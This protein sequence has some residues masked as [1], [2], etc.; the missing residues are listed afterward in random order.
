MEARNLMG[1]NWDI[2][3]VKDAPF[4]EEGLSED[5]KQLRWRKL[6]HIIF[7]CMGTGIGY[8]KDETEA[9]EWFNRYQVYSVHSGLDDYVTLD[10]VMAYIGLHTNVSRESR[11][12]WDARMRKL[13]KL[14]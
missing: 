11:F 9:R 2:T 5:E 1:L 10:D 7:A 8:I 4:K 12:Q 13:Y 14:K 3:E 6:E